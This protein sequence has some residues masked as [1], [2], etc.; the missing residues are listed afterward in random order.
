MSVNKCECV[1]E[2]VNKRPT[3]LFLLCNLQ[4]NELKTK[5][6]YITMSCKEVA[7]KLGESKL[8]EF[9]K[10]VLRE[11]V[12]KQ[13]GGLS[14][15]LGSGKTL[16]SLVVGLSCKKTTPIL[17]VVSK[18]LLES[19]KY[20]I[21]KFFGDKLKYIVLH[22]D[23]CEIEDC[24]IEDDVLLVL[25]TVDVVSKFY[26][27]GNV[28][29]KFITQKT[30]NPGEFNQHFVN[31]YNRPTTPYLNVK[32]GGYAL[33]SLK[34]SCLII[35]EVQKFTMITSMRCQGLAS[36]CAD[37]RWALSGTMFDEP[38]AERIL[39][40]YLIIND[41][42]FPRTLPDAV[43]Y[44]SSSKFRGF[45][46]STVYRNQNSAYVPPKLN[47]QII[48]HDLTTEEVK[49]YTSMK[50]TMKNINKA[51]AEYKQNEDIENV[52]KF[53]SYLLAML[54]Y[55]RQSIVC[56]ILPVA[57]ALM[58]ISDMTNKSQLSSILLDNIKDL[59][60]TNWLNDETS[61]KSSR[62][63]KVLEVVESHSDEQVVVF[64]CFRTC[65]DV[66]KHFMPTT[67][68]VFTLTSG[69]NMKKRGVIIEDFK[70]STNGVLLLTYELGAEG[71]NLQF[72][73]TV[74]LADIWWNDG[75]TQQAIGRV[76]RYGQLSSIVNVYLFTSNTGVENAVFNKQ[77]EKLTLL[78]E[79]KTGPIKSKVKRIVMKDIINLIDMEDN[80]NLLRKVVYK[81]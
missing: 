23:A 47:Q 41:K 64:T 63:T 80:K 17:V 16:T 22:Q 24:I 42:D 20:E 19:W 66:I 13:S 71:L 75:K 18:T 21:E 56:P 48:S 77:N 33:F 38:K 43:K 34:W 32:T 74:V 39:G 36:I 59:N 46:V 15:C 70:K 53:G 29:D 49:L 68:P 52:R 45:A 61:V 4:K 57:K 3:G 8:N 27:K 72:A 14:L 28:S 11:C 55:L 35:D 76:F 31:E 26:K 69:M 81:N 50:T 51:L 30:I 58:D 54:C 60:L 37:S 1:N 7:L 73:C 5:R 62:I 2:C 65:L 67:R 10:D 78:E 40:Y 25:T 6:V 12:A 44:L 9:Q 79:L